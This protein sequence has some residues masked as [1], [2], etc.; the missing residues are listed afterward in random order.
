MGIRYILSR[1]MRWIAFQ[2][3]LPK[4]REHILRTSQAMK[5][6]HCLISF[7]NMT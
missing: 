4:M 5:I 7:S 6:I 1:Y 2:R 3:R